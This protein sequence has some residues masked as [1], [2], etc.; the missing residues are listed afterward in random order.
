MHRN[1]Q[2]GSRAAAIAQQRWW[3]QQRSSNVQLGSVAVCQAWQRGGGIRLGS[4]ASLGHG[5]ASRHQRRA[6]T[7]HNRGGNEGT[8]GD[9]YG[10]GTNNQ[11]STKSTVTMTMTVTT[12]TVEMKGVAVVA[13]AWWQRVGGGSVAAA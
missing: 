8:G 9:S 13:E 10:G 12:M 3:Q 7:V 4:V 6:A 5:C 2:C 1:A 11:Q